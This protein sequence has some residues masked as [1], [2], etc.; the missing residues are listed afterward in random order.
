MLGRAQGIMAWTESQGDTARHGKCQTPK[1][2]P[3]PTAR[4]SWA[5][6][7]TKT[8]GNYAVKLEGNGRG[9]V[10]DQKAEQAGEFSSS[11]GILHTHGK[12]ALNHS[13]LLPS[14]ISPTFMQIAPA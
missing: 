4:T 1:T 9:G 12:A 6:K 2:S 5:T 7:T 11:S 8:E 14:V 13:G 3:S 10:K